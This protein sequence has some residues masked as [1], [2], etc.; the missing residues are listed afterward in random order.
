MQSLDVRWE[1]GRGTVL[2]RFG[3]AAAPDQAADARRRLVEL[4]VEAAVA[5]D[6]EG[7]WERQRAAQRSQ[8]GAVVRVSG[9]PT[10]LAAACA[11]ADAAGGTLVGRAALGLSWIALPASDTK[12]LV[13][14]IGSVRAAL[15]PAPCVVL[16]APEPVRAALDPWDRPGDSAQ[17]LMRRVKER[18][19]PTATCNPGV[20]VGGI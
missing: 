8:D 5:D 19:D 4:G 10:Q 15:A 18:F 14:R 13:D 20:F 2:A 16:D 9:V 3:G 12:T 17:V 6:D 11:A 1:G 7:L